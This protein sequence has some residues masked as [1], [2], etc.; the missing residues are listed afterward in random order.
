MATVWPKMGPG[1]LKG[2]AKTEIYAHQDYQ[3]HSTR[4]FH[5]SLLL[6]VAVLNGGGGGGT[7]TSRIMIHNDK[8]SR[9][10]VTSSASCTSCP[11]CS[12]D[13]EISSGAYLLFVLVVF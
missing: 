9:L 11:S 8:C 3:E 4:S 7:A 5:G 2:R 13:N 12:S 10:T 1:M 6:I